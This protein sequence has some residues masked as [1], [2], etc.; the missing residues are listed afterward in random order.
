MRNLGMIVTLAMLAGCLETP[1]TMSALPGGPDT[2][3]K[4]QLAGLE[5]TS[6]GDLT[7]TVQEV[8]RAIPPD[9]VGQADGAPS[10][11]TLV[12]E[13]GTLVGSYCG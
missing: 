10:R 5:G 11:L 2:C 7:I 13:D 9:Q 12:V 4:T 8:V 1:T 3:G 6:V